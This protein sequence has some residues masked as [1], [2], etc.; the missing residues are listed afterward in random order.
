[1]KLKDGEFYLQV[2][3]DDPENGDGGNAHLQIQGNWD[4]KAYELASRGWRE[5]IHPVFNVTRSWIE[6]QNY[7]RE[8]DIDDFDSREKERIIEEIRDEVYEL[9]YPDPDEKKK[10][11]VGYFMF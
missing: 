8:I 9:A 10:L 5:E 7:D 1:M 4:Y 11:P 3:I 2:V 6:Y